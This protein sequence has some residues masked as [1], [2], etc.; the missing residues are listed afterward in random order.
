MKHWRALVP[1][2]AAL[3]ISL[4]A[5]F[6]SAAET[7]TA[8]GVFLVA[9]R[10]LNDPNFRETVVLVTQHGGGAP[11]GVII[12]RP[13]R[14]S[15]AEV[16]PNNEN[17]KAAPDTL[18][19]GGPV[20]P[21]MLVFVFR[22]EAPTRDALRVL[23]DVYM[24]FNPQ[25]LAELLRRPSPT[26][27]LRVYAGYS[28]WGAGQ[29]QHEMARGDWHMVRADPET[30]FRT[31]PEKVWQEMLARATARQARGKQG[32]PPVATLSD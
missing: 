20:S 16:F 8:N 23:E 3:G 9:K 13:T 27:N 10:H 12:N 22:A 17:L 29:L 31:D 26:A 4:A 32:L 24:S 14:V 28:G 6:A 11:V 30:I 18:Y 7:Q 15:L 2:A 1:V 5:A 21:Q 19:F 25:L